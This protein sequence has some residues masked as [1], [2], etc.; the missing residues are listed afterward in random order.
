M[1]TQ[2]IDEQRNLVSVNN[3]NSIENKFNSETTV[4]DIRKELFE[5]EN[6]VIDKNTDHG[7]SELTI[8][9]EKNDTKAEPDKIPP[10]RFQV[11]HIKLIL[12]YI[13]E[14]FKYNAKTISITLNVIKKLN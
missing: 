5:D 6:V 8:N 13:I 3:V 7:L 1:L 10:L 11:K 4:S 14:I 2:T 12:K 9:K